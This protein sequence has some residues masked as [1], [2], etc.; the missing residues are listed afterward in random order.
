M[1]SHAYQ[2][3]PAP[4]H[5]GV[6]REHWIDD[7]FR[8]SRNLVAILE[9]NGRVMHANRPLPPGS[10]SRAGHVQL[11]DFFAETSRAD[12]KRLVTQAAHGRTSLFVEAAGQ[13][14]DTSPGWYSIEVTP[15]WQAN[16]VKQLMVIATDVSEHKQEEDQLRRSHALMVDTQGVAHLGVWEWDVSQPHA[17]WSPELYRIY[18][19][20]P[21]THV[22]TYADY[23]SRVHPDDRDRVEAATNHAFHELQPYSHDERI[24]RNDGELR[25]LHTWA[26]PVTDDKGRLIRLTGVCQ[27]ITDRKLA[28]NRMAEHAAE[29]ARSNARL[30][31]FARVISH[32]L[33]EPLRTI[34]SFVQLLETEN[35][36]ELGD[37]SDEAIGYIV[38][39]V[40]RMKRLI[41]DLLEYSQA[42]SVSRKHK[43][44]SL[45]EVLAA[46][47]QGL[48]PLTAQAGASIRPQPLPR[49]H[50]DKAQLLTLFNQLLTNALRFRGT[51]PPD[52]RISAKPAGGRVE[53]VV[54]DNGCGI[55]L[56]HHDRIFAVFQRLDP[57]SPGTGIGLALCK[58]II[59]RHNGKIWVESMPGQGTE[60]HFTLPVAT[61]D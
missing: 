21:A 39:G 36:G 11:A 19:L 40:H 3:P 24:Y 26:T 41:N 54:K 35:K 59:E 60:V 37:Y 44:I 23:L 12:I 31:Q 57:N 49:V 9:P 18:G 6:S 27:D 34:A 10:R 43:N 45:S 8:D 53:V 16:A 17:V 51:E 38:D 29:L 5:A 46:A 14:A 2:P 42:G 28:E 20:D 7:C 55:A 48:A 50:A 25:Y 15:L 58:A 1:R 47:E 4:V 56:E 32:D 22:P 61:P 52:I 33:Q 30:E 13:R